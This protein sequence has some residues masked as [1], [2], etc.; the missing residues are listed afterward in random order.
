MR[1]AMCPSMASGWSTVLVVVATRSGAGFASHLGCVRSCMTIP[2]TRDSEEG[3]GCLG[4]SCAWDT[5]TS[6]TR[7][8]LFGGHTTQQS[9]RS[10]ERCGAESGSWCR[11][12]VAMDGSGMTVGSSLV[13]TRRSVRGSSM[14]SGPTVRRA[15][16]RPCGSSF[17]RGRLARTALHWTGRMDFWTRASHGRPGIAGRTSSLRGQECSTGST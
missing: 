11:A 3:S 5:G 12:C 15:S 17:G 2:I 13:T 7:R 8:F 9:L 16:T 6:G 1:H 10:L 4:A 14:T